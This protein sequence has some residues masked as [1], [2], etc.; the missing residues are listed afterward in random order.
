M[1]VNGAAFRQVRSRAK[2]TQEFRYF[3]TISYK[4]YNPIKKYERRQRINLCA[5]LKEDR[6][7]IYPA[8]LL[9]LASPYRLI[10]ANSRAVGSSLIAWMVA[11]AAPRAP[12]ACTRRA[13]LSSSLMVENQKLSP[14]ASSGEDAAAAAASG[15]APLCLGGGASQM[16]HAPSALEACTSLIRSSPT[17]AHSDGR[18]SQ[19]AS[20]SAAKKGSRAGFRLG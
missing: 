18:A 1:S 2:P 15:A 19:P 9:Y 14:T 13:C 7:T 10:D 4:L 12:S 8:A 17:C 5:L 20:R 3:A 6:Y 11:E 16:A